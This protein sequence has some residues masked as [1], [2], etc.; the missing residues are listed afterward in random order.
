MRFPCGHSEP[1]TTAA[2]RI[3]ASSERAVWIACRRYNLI[4]LVCEPAN[5][6]VAK[7][8]KSLTLRTS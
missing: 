3:R 5:P 2:A 7:P 6:H 4:A 8:G 1:E